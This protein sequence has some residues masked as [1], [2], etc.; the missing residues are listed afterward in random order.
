MAKERKFKAELVS[1][2]ALFIASVDESIGNFDLLSLMQKNIQIINANISDE[3]EKINCYEQL[4]KDL[5]CNQNLKEPQLVISFY[6]SDLYYKENNYEKAIQKVLPMIKILKEEI[7]I[8][9]NPFASKAEIQDYLMLL[10]SRI[11]NSSYYL[12]NC[13]SV[14]KYV[15][16]LNKFISLIKKSKVLDSDS[17]ETNSILA[18][19][20]CMI[21]IYKNVLSL[22]MIG[23][24]NVKKEINNPSLHSNSNTNN[25]HQ[26]SRR[27]SEYNFNNL[28][29]NNNEIRNTQKI[30]C[31]ENILLYLEPDRKNLFLPSEK[32]KGSLS[33]MENKSLSID[34]IHKLF[35]NKLINHFM[36]SFDKKLKI[37]Q[38]SSEM[39]TYFLSKTNIESLKNIKIYLD[40]KIIKS[41]LGISSQQINFVNR[42]NNINLYEKSCNLETY[43]CMIIGY[44]N[45]IYLYH[46]LL[47]SESQQ[48]PKRIEDFF[49]Q[50]NG[51][52]DTFCGYF[53]KLFSVVLFTLHDNSHNSYQSYKTG[54]TPCEPDSSYQSGPSGT[55]S[56]NEINTYILKMLIENTKIKNLLLKIFFIHI[57]SYKYVKKYEDG[58]KLFDTYERI[59]LNFNLNDE[60][61]ESLYLSLLT[62]KADFLVRSK[63]Y[64]NGLN[65]YFEIL[66]I[67]DKKNDN[68]MEDRAIAL[69]NTGFAYLLKMR[70]AVGE[71]I[72]NRVNAKVDIKSAKNYLHESLN[73]FETIKYNKENSLNEFSK[74]FL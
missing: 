40:D 16:K 50:L 37:T 59:L 28:N 61:S 11:I 43:F 17:A 27:N 39:Y 36:C 25:S 19:Y 48:F 47:I 18:K 35:F 2:I 12:N 22:E 32:A 46:S 5:N 26:N 15:K 74:I 31:Y 30:S 66:R 21:A 56:S 55:S 13:E 45:L 58:L 64:V 7:F 41:D 33:F 6:L 8:E 73:L 44:Y 67:L 53:T 57:N 70:T 68:F 54:S 1:K 72:N 38:N 60:I 65:V 51:L 71:N 42:Y 34:E 69:F 23:G 4:L 10:F 20:D 14:K 3:K 63:I 9:E 29:I 52:C 24:S 62:L 49:G